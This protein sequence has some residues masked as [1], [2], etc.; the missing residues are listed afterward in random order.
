M[1]RRLMFSGSLLGAIFATAGLGLAEEGVP[2]AAR[3]PVVTVATAQPQTF[4]QLVHVSGSLVAA[5]EVQVPA[6]TGGY[7]IVDLTTEVGQTVAAGDVLARLDDQTLRAQVLQAE[8]ERARAEAALH[9]SQNQITSTEAAFQQ[10]QV[11]LDRTRALKDSG[12]ATQAALDDALTA[13][14]S[15]QASYNAARDGVAVAQAALQSA[16]AA[17]DIA[18]RNLTNATI[19]APVAGIIAARSAELGMIASAGG[20][21]LFTI[22][23]DGEVE[24]SVEVIET[25]LVLLSVGDPVELRVAGLPPVHGT[26]RRVSPVVD[27]STRVG[28]VRITITEQANLRP[29]MFA[30]GT[31]TVTERENLGVPASAVLV[32]GEEDYVLRVV[33]GVLDRVS[34]QTGLLWQNDMEIL[35]GLTQGDVVVARAGAFFAAGDQVQPL[36]TEGAE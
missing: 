4:E 5:Q 14:T 30:A 3:I 19:V 24:A 12:T 15:A 36:A 8:G 35:N 9:Q 29:G 21:P 25:D 1:I 33:D 13:H 10:A 28:E 32:D 11:A 22:I 27:D 2:T 31:I 18:S 26:V 20:G 23:R 17:L 34:V 6:L 7:A 16:E